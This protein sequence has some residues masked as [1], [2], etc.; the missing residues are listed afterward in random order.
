M[1]SNL[2]DARIVTPVDTQQQSRRSRPVN[3][4]HTYDTAASPRAPP[5]MTGHYLANE[6]PPG[7][8]SIFRQA[9]L[10]LESDHLPLTRSFGSAE[11]R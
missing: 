6:L 8:L 1:N 5:P 7:S 11:I 10:R 2:Y 9:P 3:F 4:R